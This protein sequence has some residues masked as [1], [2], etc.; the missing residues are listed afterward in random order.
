LPNRITLLITELEPGGAER[1]LVEL[2]TR[3]PSGEF[4]PNVLVLAPPPERRELVDRLQ[5]AGIRLEFLGAVSKSQFP[6]IHHEVAQRLGRQKDSLLQCFLHHA[7]VQGS[8]AAYKAG[9]RRV[10]TGIRVADR[11]FNRRLLARWTDRYV[12]R[13]VC[14]S[15]AVAEFAAERMYLPRSKLI[16]IPNGVDAGRFAGAIPLPREDLGVRSD[17]RVITSIGRLDRQKRLPWLFRQVRS[18]QRSIPDL[19]VVLV[20]EGPEEPVLRSLAASLGISRRIHFVGWRT[21]IPRVLA[22]SDLLVLTSAWEGMPNVVLEAMAAGK[23][24]V[25][26]E[27]EGVVEALG[28]LAQEPV[29]QSA[30]LRAEEAFCEA[31]VRL[32]EDPELARRVGWANQARVR[33]EF[34]FERMIERY[35]HLYREMLSADEKGT[36]I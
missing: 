12:A 34:S 36:L 25:A 11:R 6:A 5:A 4:E 14:V 8:Y 9:F 18:I 20:G 31:V 32:L 19:E 27:A 28:P 7:N 35:C 13:H 10:L 1:Q 30:S 16:T 33:E 17:S 26:T 22:A 21:D 23:P 24:V 15:Q 2:A 29:F 3:L